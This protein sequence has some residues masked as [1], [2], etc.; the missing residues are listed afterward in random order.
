MTLRHVL[1]AT[2]FGIAL[3]GCAGPGAPRAAD[4]APGRDPSAAE[5]LNA[6]AAEAMNADPAAAEGLLRRAVAADPYFGPAHNNLGVLHLTA[7]RLH[8][9]AQALETARRLMPGHPDPRLNLALT[10]EAAGRDADAADAYRA[11][12]EVFPG[13][14]PSLQGLTRLQ[15]RSGTA[16]ASTADALREIALRGESDAWRAWARL[17]LARTGGRGSSVGE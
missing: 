16:D 8:E 7:G 13:H 2:L 15:V 1:R 10:L 12:I 9:A 11:A 6:T 5:R 4:A 14:V 17:E 3:A